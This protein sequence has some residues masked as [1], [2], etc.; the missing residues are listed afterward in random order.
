MLF[1]EFFTKQDLSTFHAFERPHGAGV[2]YDVGVYDK[3]EGN[4]KQVT[5]LSKN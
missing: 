5:S 3:T 1:K 2:W 4:R